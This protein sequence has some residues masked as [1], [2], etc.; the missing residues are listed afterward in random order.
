MKKA[1]LVTILLLLIFTFPV[2]AQTNLKVFYS[3]DEGSVLTALKLIPG[4]DIV[5][6]LS[7]ADVIVLNGSS[8]DP[9]LVNA[10][11]EAGKGLVLIMGTQPGLSADA[12]SIILGQQVRLTEQTSPLSLDTQKGSQDSLVSAIV[13]SSA[14]QIRERQVME[15]SL[16]MTAVVVGFETKE[17][18]L[19]SLKVGKGEVFVFTSILGDANPQIQ[20]WAYFNYLIY[21]LVERADGQQP[22]SFADYPNSPVPHRNDQIILFAILGGMLAIP[23][24]LYWFV[25]RYSKRHPEALDNIVVNR[26]AFTKLEARTDWE[27]IG[28]HRPLGGFFL[29]MFLGLILFVPLIIYQN[30][31]LPAYI[32]PSAQ[33]IGIWGR[34]TQFFNL[35]WLFF[36]MGTSIAFV[37]F[38]SQYRIH[39]P[40]EG[41]KYGQVFVW[42]QLLSGAVQ[43][44]I[45]VALSGTV[46]P[47]SAYAIYSWSVIIH[48][49]IQIPGFYQF[50]R[51]AFTGLQRFDFAQILDV[52]LTLVFPMIT[53]PIIVT[54]F[55]MWGR[56]HPIFGGSIGGLLGMGVAAYAT[57]LLT[58]LLG[59]LLYRRLGYNVRIYFL[60]HF[61]WKVIKNSFKFGVFNMI[62][63]G[64]WGIGQSIE[65]LITQTY[66]VNYAEVWGN[67]VLAQNFVFAFQV[68]QT[69]YNNLMPSWSE[70][71]SNGRKI[72]STFYSALAY[73]WGG[74][75][76]GFVAAVLLAVGD[77]FIIG[78]SGPEFS[79]AAIYAVPLLIWGAVQFPSW[80]GDNVQLGSNKPWLMSLMIALEQTIRIVLAF[81]LVR[82]LQ[83][84]ALIIAYFVAIMI[85]NITA[86]FINNKYCFQQKFYFWQS[87]FAPL[88]A[89]GAHYL[90]IRWVSGLIWKSDQVTSIIILFIGL[91]PSYPLYAFF[92]GLFG[93]WEDA[94]LADMH[95]ALA[96]SSFMKPFAW[97]WWRSSSLG[98]R[99][100]PLRNRFV[101]DIRQAALE[102]AKSLTKEK[103]SL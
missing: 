46:L 63:S 71:I 23:S 1:L 85:K 35:I 26:K 89:A 6:D 78:A 22:F 25:R 95:R 69:L 24:F 28:F 21:H 73:K 76:S 74:V 92:V 54:L 82:F 68:L 77:R 18:V 96:L 94:D 49:F 84:N 59:M 20:E 5:P 31:I 75:I 15:T 99:V 29:A 38:F 55:V 60:A 57:E 90:V 87:L 39:D 27:D 44:A 70:A 30:L 58:F 88:L 67:W 9:T 37:K 91:L 11:V 93:G 7:A 19:S 64:L 97:L 41:I 40:K 86:Y 10:Q 2:S 33:A 36:D 42:W 83:I 45:V 98:A 81:A 34:V 14:P 79:R 102:E 32:L 50:Y 80:V 61:D 16:P 53:Q 101:M 3:G 62:G 17:T 43:V 66:L 52:G 72:L 4:I 51:Y 12:V 47:H 48:T 103:V 100:S 8:V 65:I 13:W 56:A